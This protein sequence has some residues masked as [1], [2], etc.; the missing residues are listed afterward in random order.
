MYLKGVDIM[1]KII[2]LLNF[3]LMINIAASLVF[4]TRINGNDGLVMISF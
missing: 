4:N 1:K 3:V 2:V